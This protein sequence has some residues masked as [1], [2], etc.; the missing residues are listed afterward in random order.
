MPNGIREFIASPFLMFDDA[1]V[2][3]KK[4]PQSES[5]HYLA[6]QKLI[7]TNRNF[8]KLKP[9]T[10]AKKRESKDPPIPVLYRLVIKPGIVQYAP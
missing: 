3:N 5:N 8:L 6:E 2:G 4:A 9:E 1:K 10:F 7:E